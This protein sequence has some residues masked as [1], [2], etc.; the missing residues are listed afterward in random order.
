MRSA[1]AASCS[2]NTAY[3]TGTIRLADMAKAEKV[4]GPV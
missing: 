4:T 3:P 1:V 2:N